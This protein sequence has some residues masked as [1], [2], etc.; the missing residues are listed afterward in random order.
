MKNWARIKI[1]VLVSLLLLLCFPVFSEGENSPKGNIIGFIYDQ[2]CTTPL[3]GAVVK[4]KNISSGTIYESNKSDSN[5]VFAIDGVESGVYLYG[6]LTQQGEFGA[7]NFFGVRVS[8]GETAKLS[9]S[10][11]PYEQKV[12]AAMQEVYKEQAVAGESLVGT[13]IDYNSVSGTAEV[14]LVK[15]LLRL[16]DKIHAKGKS[17]DF[18]QNVEEMKLGSSPVKKLFAGQTANLK[19]KDSVT[20]GDLIYVIC[21]RGVLP[22][23][24]KPIGLA[25]IIAG[26]AGVVAGIS[27]AANK[28]AKTTN[29][30]SEFKN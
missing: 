19:M 7:E 8:E 1:A 24:L 25:S 12:A 6:V 23:F 30:V 9:V 20:N 28:T 18:Y 15:G 5:G 22:F 21:K 11:T 16:N 10:L 29:N 27:D 13:V 2:D 26:S 3:E 4:V 17:T 14:L